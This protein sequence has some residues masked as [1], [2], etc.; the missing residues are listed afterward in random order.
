LYGTW[1]NEEYG[2]FYKA[3][4]TS[5]GKMFRY[6]RGADKPFR[7]SRFSIVKSW[8]DETGNTYFEITAMQSGYPYNDSRANK[9]YWLTRVNAAGD[10]LEL[11]RSPT[12]FPSEVSKSAGKYTIH[13]RR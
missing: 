1:V 5:D 6:N 9:W 2:S 13:Y 4:I 3:E 10:T 12:A 11:V 8:T 7:V